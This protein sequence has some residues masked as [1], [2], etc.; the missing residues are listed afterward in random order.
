[1][2]TLIVVPDHP[3][4]F[5][6]SALSERN[7]VHA[8]RLYRVRVAETH[9]DSS[10]HQRRIW[11]D[12][13]ITGALVQRDRLIEI[14]LVRGSRRRRLPIPVVGDIAQADVGAGVLRIE[15][16]RGLEGGLSPPEIV[17]L[18]AQPVGAAKE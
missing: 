16:D 12:A 5:V 13:S 14:A 7:V 2:Q 17:L 8:L 1:M 10:L 9:A 18:V 6:V 4:E 15:P 3:L 11:L